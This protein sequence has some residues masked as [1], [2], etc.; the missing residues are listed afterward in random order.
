MIFPQKVETTES[1]EKLSITPE[2]IKPVP[3][4]AVETPQPEIPADELMKDIAQPVMEKKDE[5][6]Q[7]CLF[8]IDI[9]EQNL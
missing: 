3:P 4:L 2:D 7:D 9:A 8:L 5:G 1:L 6:K